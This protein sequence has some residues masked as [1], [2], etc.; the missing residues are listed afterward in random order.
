[1]T[2]CCN[3]PKPNEFDKQLKRGLLFI[4]LT[5]VAFVTGV[6]CLLF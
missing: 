2:K 1:M 3:V 6:V 4:G 5:V